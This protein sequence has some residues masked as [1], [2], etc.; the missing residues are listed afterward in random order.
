M[1]AKHK[2]AK[3]MNTHPAKMVPDQIMKIMKKLKKDHA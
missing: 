2:P 3:M 1:P